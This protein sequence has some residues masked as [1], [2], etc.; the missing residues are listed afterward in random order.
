METYLA[1]LNGTCLYNRKEGWEK[2]EK[3]EAESGLRDSCYKA[4]GLCKNCS[5][6]LKNLREFQTYIESKEPERD[7]LIRLEEKIE[8]LEEK[9]D[10]LIKI[11]N[12]LR[13]KLWYS[14]NSV[15]VPDLF[16]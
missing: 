8:K 7:K 13:S 12:D 1:I 3:W 4:F 9:V 10:A 6:T 14:G 2:W 15:G 5:G 11:I 16:F